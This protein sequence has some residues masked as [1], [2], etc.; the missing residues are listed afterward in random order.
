VAYGNGVWLAGSNNTL[1][2][3]TDPEKGW[4][5]VENENVVDCDTKSIVYT[6]KSWAIGDSCGYVYFT[7][8]PTT[9]MIYKLENSIFHFCENEDIPSVSGLASANGLTVAVG[10]DD[11]NSQNIAITEDL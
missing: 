10:Y 3:S 11:C 8:D 6:G 1:V 7:L 9:G 2:Y 4:T 5:V